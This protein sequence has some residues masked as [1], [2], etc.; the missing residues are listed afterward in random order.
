MRV[1]KYKWGLCEHLAPSDIIYQHSKLFDII[2]IKHLSFI[3]QSH[4]TLQ[5]HVYQSIGQLGIPF[6][7]I[8]LALLY[9]FVNVCK[10]HFHYIVFY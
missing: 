7:I 10:T 6:S 9:L 8:I 4:M 1:Q 3:M 2:S 5:A